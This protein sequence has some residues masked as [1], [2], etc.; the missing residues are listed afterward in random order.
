MKTPE[1]QRTKRI[2]IAVLIPVSVLLIA[3]GIYKL[4]EGNMLPQK[5][6]SAKNFGIPTVKSAVDKNHNGID[7]YTDI[8]LGAR[9]YVQTRPKYQSGYYTGGYP[10]DGVGVCTD[11]IWKA[12]KN[13]GYSLKDMVDEDI[14]KN[15][16]DYPQIKVQDKSIDFRRVRNLNIFFKRNARSLTLD[17]KDIREWQPGDIVVFSHPDHIAIV[18][19]KRNS[20]GQPYI[21]HNAGQP[22]YEVDALA[23]YHIAG[24][25]R[26]TE[27]NYHRL[28]ADG[29][30]LRLKASKSW[31]NAPRIQTG[32]TLVPFSV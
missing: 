32:H 24:H 9:A 17:P 18:S 20:R 3:A 19:D 14:A 4:N 10:P 2:I 26:W 13:A 1:K 11:V 27:V 22:V 25:Y 16:A 21:I 15:R 31:K 23:Q 30:N 29:L 6:Y 8:L 7:D 28:N 12:F 5:T